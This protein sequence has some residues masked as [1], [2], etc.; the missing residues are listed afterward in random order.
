M[1][2]RPEV[3][4]TMSARMYADHSANAAVRSVLGD[5]ARLGDTIEKLEKQTASQSPYDTP[6]AHLKKVNANAKKLQE[7][8]ANA[9]QRASELLSAEYARTRVAINEKAGLHPTENAAEIRS[10]LRGMKQSERNA[11]LQKALKNKDTDILAAV[12]SGSEL[13][14]GFD[15]EFRTRMVESYTREVAPDLHKQLDDIAEVEKVLPTIWGVASKAAEES[16]D[17]KL[18]ADN[19]K[20]AE[21]AAQSEAEFNAAF[22]GQGA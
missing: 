14:T 3:L 15:D 21:L 17:Q 6:A 5:V 4:K 19:E 2:S 16:V 22:S 13:L 20:R 1:S 11:V 8:V 10:V 18:L 7:H 12:A 9:K